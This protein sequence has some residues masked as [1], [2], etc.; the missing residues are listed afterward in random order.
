M[1]KEKITVLQTTKNLQLSNIIAQAIDKIGDLLGETIV[2]KIGGKLLR[3]HDLLA[4]FAE[5]VILLKSVGINVII[6]HGGLSLVDQYLEEFS[7]KSSSGS[8]F[9]RPTIELI[10]MVMTGYISKHIVNAINL[11]GGSAISISGK[12]V[13]LISA[14]KTKRFRSHSKIESIVDVSHIGEI[15]EINPEL[16]FSLEDSG[17]IPV[18]SPIAFS[19]NGETYHVNSD[20]LALEIAKIY[21]VFRPLKTG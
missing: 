21:S 12:D 10:E 14:K 5:N 2:I 13:N 19:E 20:E 15:S 17:L 9:N 7:I 1:I 4:I 18:L 8:I 11:K 3:D 16:L 6:I